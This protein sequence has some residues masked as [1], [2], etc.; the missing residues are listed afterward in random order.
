MIVLLDIE[1]QKLT[2]YN[3]DGMVDIP[4]S[5]ALSIHEY[6]DDENV[7]YI[8]NAIEVSVTDILDMLKGM[9]VAVQEDNFQDTGVKYLHSPS[10]G[11]LYIDEN[12][13]FEGKFDCKII[14]ETLTLAIE[15]SHLL[16][17]LIRSKK[18]EIIGTRG[19]KKLAGEFKK[20]QVKKA[21]KQGYV[22]A[23]L[24]SMILKGR[25]EDWDGTISGDDGHDDAIVVDIGG[26]GRVGTGSGGVGPSFN[27]MSEL[28]DNIDGLEG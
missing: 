12:L 20:F 13:V 19:R 22:D 14:D 3:K 25:V 8:T 7:L 10:E 1:K 18:L 27:T 11:T 5:Q 9:G 16:Q 2:L 21:E 15:H 6:V 4:F 28:M 17:N 24:D 23:Q 26:A